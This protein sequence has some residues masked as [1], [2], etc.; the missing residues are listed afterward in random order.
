[1]VTVVIVEYRIFRRVRLKCADFSNFRIHM[2]KNP[3]CTAV[4]FI[5]KDAADPD[6]GNDAVF[7]FPKTLSVGAIPEFYIISAIVVKINRF[8]LIFSIVI[9]PLDAALGH[10]AAIV[11]I[12]GMAV[13][14][15][16]RMRLLY[17]VVGV[18]G[19]ACFVI[20]QDLQRQRRLR[21]VAHYRLRWLDAVDDRIHD[22][23]SA[24]QEKNLV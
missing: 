5:L 24:N 8:K 17:R 14:C 21:I 11:I 1:M 3:A 13:G 12:I 15:S 23:F 18:T 20:A 22:A 19:A 9:Q 7:L 6:I 4:I 16:H 2:T 10:I